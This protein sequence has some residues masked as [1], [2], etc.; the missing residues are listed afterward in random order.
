M[1][2]LADI[3]APS[4]GW[5]EGDLPTH[6]GTYNDSTFF[7]VGSHSRRPFDIGTAD[8]VF[9]FDPDGNDAK[10]EFGSTVPSVINFTRGG[11]YGIANEWIVITL[12]ANEVTYDENSQEVLTPCWVVFITRSDAASART[13]AAL[14]G[15][16]TISDQLY[17]ITR[18]YSTITGFKDNWRNYLY[19]A[20]GGIVQRN[21]HLV[22]SAKDAYELATAGETIPTDDVS[23]SSD[24]RILPFPYLIEENL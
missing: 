22:M 15:R 5:L 11:V 23:W 13:V 21:R 9:G 6:Y 3:A 19:W 14:E 16:H 20:A 12:K 2:F 1:N 17:K 8:Q 18:L 7:G 10:A 4:P 24:I